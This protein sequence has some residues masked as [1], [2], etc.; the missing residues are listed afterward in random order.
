MLLANEL[1]AL[2]QA[3]EHRFGGLQRLESGSYEG[4]G[5][6]GRQ[7][8]KRVESKAPLLAQPGQRLTREC[9]THHNRHVELDR[10]QRDGVRH[11][12]FFDQ[13]WNQ[14]LVGRTAKRLS[15]T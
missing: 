3:Y 5:H 10:I 13:R 1:N 8:R 9:W 15:E 12:F 11:V 4:Q 14:R 2:L 7:K 6:D